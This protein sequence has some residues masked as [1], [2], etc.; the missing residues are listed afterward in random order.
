[1]NSYRDSLRTWLEAYNLWLQPQRDGRPWTW[2]P[3][4]GLRR[5]LQDRIWA[6]IHWT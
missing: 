6:D 2:E 1:M 3:I 4:P 5:A